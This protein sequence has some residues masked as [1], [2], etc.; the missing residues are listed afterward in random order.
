MPIL[1]L[2]LNNTNAESLSHLTSVAASTLTLLVRNSRSMISQCPCR[3][4]QCNGVTPTYAY[5]MFIEI[6]IYITLTLI[7]DA[8]MS[9]WAAV[10]LSST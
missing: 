7:Y 6:Y 9:S 5:I 2:P 1:N 4:A 3:A 8:R 10:I